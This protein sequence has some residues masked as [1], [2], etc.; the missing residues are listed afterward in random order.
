MRKT[1]PMNFSW[2]VK[3][4]EENDLHK[5][6]FSLCKKVEI[7]NQPIDMYPNY[8]SIKQIE[9]KF[10]YYYMI[11]NIN[12]DPYQ[13]VFLRFEGVSVTCEIYLNKTLVGTNQNGYTT[14]Q[15]DIK[16]FIDEKI[17]S[18]ELLVIVSGIEEKDIP[19]FGGV[20]D[21]LG[22]VGIYREVY[23]DLLTSEYIKDVFMYADDPLNDDHLKLEVE[24]TGQ[25]GSLHVEVLNIEKKIVEQQEFRISDKKSLLKINVY[26]KKLWELHN[27]Y[28]YHVTVTYKN[29][30]EIYDVYTHKF[31]FRALDFR[32]D[33]FYI[34]DK[35][36]KL[37]GI[38]RHQSFPY[39]GYA[40][41]K[42]AQREDADILKRKLGIDIVRSSHYPCSTH[43]LD[44]CDEIGI[45][46]LEEIPGWQY[47][48][49]ETFKKL[50]YESLTRMIKRDKNH[51]SICL[52]GVRINESADDHDFYLKTNEIARTLDF[53]RQT[54]GIR[55]IDHSE[56]LEDVY[57]YNDFSHSG[58][59]PGVT[60]KKKVTKTNVPYL[61]TEHNGHMFP[62]K[63]FDSESIMLE[64]AKRHLRVINDALAPDS[65]ISGAIGWVMSDYQTHPS[66][67]SVD[68][69]CY[70]GLLDMYRMPKIASYG[71][72]SQK[73]NPFILEV[74]SSMRIGEY[75]G[76]QL[77]EVYI[78]TNLDYVKVFKNDAYLNTLY[79]HKESYP[80]LK[81]PPIIM[82]DFIGDLI[83][84][85]EN[86]TKKDAYAVK[87]I[88][89]YVIK[90]GNHLK[91]KHKIKM[92][93]LLKKYRM[94][95]DDGVKLFYKYTSGWGNQGSSYRFEGYKE[96]VKVKEV[97]KTYDEHFI[98]NVVQSK[99]EMI[100]DDTYDSLRFEVT[101]TDQ[102]QQLKPYLF[103]SCHIDVVGSA[104][105]IGPK[106]QTIQSGQLAFWIKSKA[107]GKAFIKIKVRDQIVEKEV[108]IR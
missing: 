59:N 85:D 51:A 56:M 95:Y 68:G 52:W 34:N 10:S 88:I 77:D 6:D 18:Q 5:V 31:G 41:P 98:V 19:P 69:I 64:Q 92:G 1:I 7:P 78:F 14:Y 96:D 82:N 45:L 28:L 55:N 61:I 108:T 102:Y 87:K 50:S 4:F 24:T 84:Q 35:H 17:D 36:K 21:F 9:Q 83:E 97:I 23:L 73:D 72:L 26:D 15:V 22:Y 2:F 20:V 89:E 46:V 29:D 75:P 67:G 99:T 39:Q 47:I 16:D 25:T 57:T 48:G 101:C 13:H 62:V 12:F 100:Q 8:F 81:H 42:S 33:G 40:M 71:Y 66:F 76:G 27:P 104:T 106:I 105:L 3:P 32:D 11:E 60:P 37:I 49:N 44:R 38:N 93:L 91:L 53:T 54:C 58:K 43:F 65:H 80:H 79:P 86:M 103:E 90:N 94:S 74:S 70:H 30:H 107:K 63:P